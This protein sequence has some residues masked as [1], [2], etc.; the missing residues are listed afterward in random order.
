MTH[1]ERLHVETHRR[2]S[3]GLVAL[4]VGVMSSFGTVPVE[5]ASL[6]QPEFKQG[7]CWFEICRPFIPGVGPVFY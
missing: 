1:N 4:F 2:I 3:A 6:D 5:V 7:L